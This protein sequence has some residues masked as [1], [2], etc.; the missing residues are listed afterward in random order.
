MALD[1]LRPLFE[2][3][4][5]NAARNNGIPAVLPT[6]RL[7]EYVSRQTQIVATMVENWFTTVI[8]PVLPNAAFIFRRIQPRPNLKPAEIIIELQAK[9]ALFL[10][11]APLHPPVETPLA[12]S[13]IL[14]ST[15]FDFMH[16]FVEDHLRPYLTGKITAKNE[17]KDRPALL[18]I[19]LPLLREKF[20]LLEDTDEVIQ[21]KLLEAYVL[22]AAHGFNIQ[23]GC[24]INPDLYRDTRDVNA[25]CAALKHALRIDFKGQFFSN[26]EI[27]ELA[28][29]A[30]RVF[31]RGRN[32]SDIAIL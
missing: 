28:E 32:I 22:E 3:F 1:F 24:C 13:P 29:D 8:V 18:P 17:N 11:A 27:Y 15:D 23:K 12:R 5:A 19:F 30:L 20:P 10:H 26:L 21:Q 6:D 25:F 4:A 2:G 14:E 31:L 16:A 9:K 7:F